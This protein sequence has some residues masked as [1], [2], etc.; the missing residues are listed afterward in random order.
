MQATLPSCSGGALYSASPIAL[1]KLDYILPL[2]TFTPLPSDHMYFLIAHESATAPNSPT[3]RV[4][5]FAP[6][7]ITV[8]QI[9]RQVKTTNGAIVKTDYYMYFAPC[10][11]VRGGFAHMTSLTG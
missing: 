9:G 4:N 11:E 1:D 7:N 6:G 10:R 3:Q 8:F 2:G 5:V